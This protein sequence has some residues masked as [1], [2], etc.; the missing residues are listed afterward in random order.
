MN[1]LR[2]TLLILGLIFIGLYLISPRRPRLAMA[3]LRYTILGLGAALTL[4]PFF[5]LVCAAFK[6]A[7]VLMRYTFLPPVA[8][9]APA[10]SIAPADILDGAALC[11]RLAASA[12]EGGARAARRVWDALPEDGRATV[13]RIAA[14]AAEARAKFE[15][16]RDAVER[17]RGRQ[18]TAA[19][20]AALDAEAARIQSDYAARRQALVAPDDKARLAAALGRL[21][22][23]RDLYQAEAFGELG[24]SLELEAFKKQGI[25]TLSEAQRARL[26]RHLLER[27]FPD[28]LRGSRRLNTDNFK[29][30]FA[31]EPTAQGTVYF[32]QYLL[33]SLFLASATTMIQLFFCSLG[34]YALA[35]YRFRG[36]HVLVVYM[37]STL[38][39]PGVMLLAPVYK[40]ICSIG[41]S[42]SY[43]ALLVPGAAG[44]FG[45]FL[46][47]QAIIAVP[48]ELI[49]AARIDG[50]G[51]F[52]IY[53]RLIMPLVKPMTAA[54]CL[55]VF[56]GSWNNFLGPQIFLSTQA[57]LTLPVVLNQ[58]IG[59]YSQQYGVFLAGTLLSIIP[60]AILFFALQRE[61]VSGL[62]SGALKG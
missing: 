32:W 21:L 8:E 62:T 14:R 7:D 30:L 11:E 55:V 50:C 12:N 6:D 26:N 42:D 46:F 40:L 2:W 18:A 24:K 51:E 27:V 17:R 48:D 57:K 45:I 47:R 53:L 22:D 60:P 9:W 1:G 25:E 38:M 41:W 39:A 19:D 13:A 10:R 54:F 34:G 15:K 36:R 58:Y 20:A 44:V 43:L 37:I 56:L 23:R 33:N 52:G 49:E 29:T 16:Q 59:I 5:W 3:Y 35:K 4:A 31:G 61:F 28:E